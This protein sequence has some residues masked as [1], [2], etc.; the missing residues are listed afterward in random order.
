MTILLPV[1]PL[2]EPHRDGAGQRK[3]LC[4][5]S[6]WAGILRGRCAFSSD[7]Q[8]VRKRDGYTT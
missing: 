6:A 1:T 7:I 3:D 8:P 4:M 2:L 5:V